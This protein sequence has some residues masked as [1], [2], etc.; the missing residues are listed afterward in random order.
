MVVHIKN[1]QA[2][3][4]AQLQGQD[5]ACSWHD[6][7]RRVIEEVELGGEQQGSRYWALFPPLFRACWGGDQWHPQKHKVKMSYY[8]F[9]SRISSLLWVELPVQAERDWVGVRKV[10]ST[11]NSSSI[12]NRAIEGI[13]RSPPLRCAFSTLSYQWIIAQRILI[14]KSQRFS[15]S[16]YQSLF[17]LYHSLLRRWV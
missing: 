12:F 16:L 10:P 3:N 1:N 15:Q 7:G 4:P 5:I 11:M 2:S 9:F 6:P 17:S 8:L 13:K 14:K